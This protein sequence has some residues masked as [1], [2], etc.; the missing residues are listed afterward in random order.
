MRVVLVTD[1]HAGR[2]VGERIQIIRERTGKSRPV[3][4]GLVG[5]SAEWLKAV[6][7]GRRQP[8]RLDMLMQ[9]GE[10]LGVR[11]LAELTGEETLRIGL[12]R[13]GSHDVVPAIREAIEAAHL[14]VAVEPRPD[15]LFLKEQT[16]RAWQVWHT[17]RTPR[18]DAGAMLPAIIRDGRR[19]VRVLDGQERRA[20][21]R[22]LAGAYALSEQVL[23]WVADPALLWLAAD[24]CM[25]CAQ[26][27][28]DPETLAAAAWVLGN[29]WRSTGRE[30]GAWNLAQDASALLEPHL[31]DGT[32]NARALWGASQ[33]HASIT[34]ARVGREGDALRCL[35]QADAMTSRLSA[36]YAHA[37][38][39][40]GKANAIMTGVSVNVDLHKSGH[41]LDYANAG[42]L[43]AVPSIDRRARLW[44]EL[45]RGY[46]QRK[47]AMSTLHVLQRATAIS[48]ESM[49]CHP[50]ARSIAGELVITGGRLVEN[51]ARALASQLGLT[52]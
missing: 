1:E 31:A 16:E 29:V 40:F 13:R 37:W 51:E 34:A 6:E 45:A 21:Y 23:A 18:A 9:L 28:D 2:T 27:A 22:A 46:S 33:L 12:Q 26:Q 25:D 39:L 3:V 47:D 17:S 19:A 5:R 36:G 4:A 44:L 14:A 35:D 50:I 41:A 7:K 15:A 42:D 32:D 20:A 48:E 24:R 8:P 49:R 10:V 43:D 11:D 30:D 52:V 38:T